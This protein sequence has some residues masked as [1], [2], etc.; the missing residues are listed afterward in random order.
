MQVTTAR[1]DEIVQ[2]G[3]NE[4]STPGGV[5][6]KTGQSSWVTLTAPE[7]IQEYGSYSTGAIEYDFD[8]WVHATQG[9][10][11]GTFPVPGGDSWSQDQTTSN[12][13]RT[14]KFWVPG[15][16]GNADIGT[17]NIEWWARYTPS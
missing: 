6:T 2:V 17:Y 10:G 14:I 8:S 4:F 15:K 13:G 1:G 3:A 12:G 11:S 7:K 9:F 16:V 5:V